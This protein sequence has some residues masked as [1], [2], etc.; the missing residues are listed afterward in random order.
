MITYSDG[1]ARND[2]IPVGAAH[3]FYQSQEN[4]TAKVFAGTV[5]SNQP[6]VAAVIQETRNATTGAGLIFSY[7]GFTG[8]ATNLV[9]PLIN[10]NNAGYLTGLQIQNIGTQAT[11]VT[12]TYTP[13]AAGTQ[14]SETQTIA[15]G[16][17]TTYAL[18]AFHSTAPVPGTANCAK[19]ARF[20]G[21]AQVTGNS[22]NQPLVG[23]GNQ[24]LPGINGGAYSAFNVDQATNKVVLPLMMDR[25]SGFFTGFNVQN[26]GS[27][28]A[29][30]SC[31][32]TNDDYTIPATQLAP[33][34]A[35]NDLQRNKIADNYVGGAT[36]TASE[37]G[38]K[39]VA[40]VNE[41]GSS[42]TADQLLVYEGIA[43][44]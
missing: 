23:I 9:F 28:T 27:V 3:F 21:S 10:A 37:A 30:I 24:L 4:H 17:S 26:V 29:T 38:A 25:N 43:T 40:I 18:A 44:Q 22:T 5:T 6:V 8:G 7:T 20:I 16:A 42:T 41:L 35:L 15:P 1:L 2:T 12:L 19:G 32:F 39:I 33:G 31:T 34:A 36:C 11:E 14:C 13:S